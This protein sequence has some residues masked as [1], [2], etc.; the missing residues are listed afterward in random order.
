MFLGGFSKRLIHARGRLLTLVGHFSWEKT[1]AAGCDGI[2]KQFSIFHFGQFPSG[3]GT[4]S[5]EPSGENHFETS[6]GYRCD[7]LA[8]LRRAEAADRLQSSFGEMPQGES[9]GQLDIDSEDH[10]SLLL[11][12][13]VF[14]CGSLGPGWPRSLSTQHH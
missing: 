14:G 8:R 7:D 9:A 12:G 2:L 3:S 1:L 10:E 5:L 4:A 13:P 11:T 6:G